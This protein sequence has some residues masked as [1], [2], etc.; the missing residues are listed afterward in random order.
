MKAPPWL[1]PPKPKRLLIL[2]GLLLALVVG[3]KIYRRWTPTNSHTTAHYVIQ[4]SALP[5]QTEDIGAKLE[6]L[7]AAYVDLFKSWP[8]VQQ[9]HALLKVKLFKDRQEFQRCNRGIGWAE[10]FY[11]PPYCH[12]YYSADEI[13][14]YHWMLHEAVH[15]L[16]HEVAHLNL[17]KWADEGLSDYL[18]SSLLVGGQINA[19]RT[20][21]NTYPVW[22]LD[23]L[24]LSGDLNRDLTNGTIIPLRAIITGSGGPPMNKDFNLYYLHW[25]SLMHLL[26]DG[27]GGKYR[28]GVLPLLQEGATLKSFEKHIG[29]VERVQAEWYR[30]LQ[31]L[32]WSLFRV[33]TPPANHSKPRS[34]NSS[35][36][37]PK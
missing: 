23:E 24:Q 13:N 31:E 32:Q 16:N 20:D 9:P 15:Q 34:V 37:S 5:S 1:L 8:E 2:F 33:S 17:A 19:G 35:S 25:W 11:R 29:P 30:H 36:S 12:A 7:H 22:W 10:A 14:P 27:E 3:D 4:S 26:F 28:A 6:A 21:R 18:G